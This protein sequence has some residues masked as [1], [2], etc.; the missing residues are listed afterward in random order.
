M[1]TATPTAAY[2]LAAGMTILVNG[3]EAVTVAEVTRRDSRW[4]SNGV[5][6]FTATNG[7][8]YGLGRNERVRF[9]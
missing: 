7:H 9:A 3:S 8:R 5:V 4:V 1:D 2:D 6:V